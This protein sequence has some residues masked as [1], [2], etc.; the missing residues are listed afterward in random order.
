MINLASK[1]YGY[2]G[3]ATKAGKVSFGTEAV[4]ETITKYKAKLILIASDCSERTLKNFQKAVTDYHVPLIVFGTIEE[5]SKAIGKDNKA[6]VA[7]K[8]SNISKE[9][10]K[11][12]NGGGD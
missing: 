2:L 7:V 11:L 8:D 6:V 9:I 10:E 4:M 5:L 12:I 1:V 3:L